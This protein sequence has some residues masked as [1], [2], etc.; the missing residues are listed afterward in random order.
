MSIHIT[1]NGVLKY[2]Y[3]FS[4]KLCYIISL[5]KSTGSQRR[6]K[7]IITSAS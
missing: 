7:L 1:E 5:Q 3:T 2:K 4:L 6:D